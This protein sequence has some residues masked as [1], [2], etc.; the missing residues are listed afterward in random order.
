MLL[1]EN[2]KIGTTLLFL[3]VLFLCFGVVLFSSFFLSLGK[4]DSFV[5]TSIRRAQAMSCF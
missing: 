2:Q 5:A 4:C 1:S 3:G